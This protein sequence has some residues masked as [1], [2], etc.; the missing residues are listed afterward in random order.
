MS[1]TAS[2]CWATASIARTLRNELP[3]IRTVP[4]AFQSKPAPSRCLHSATR[5]QLSSPL[6]ATASQPQHPHFRARHFS[7]SRSQKYKTV[8][9]AESR[10]RSGPFSWAAGALFLLSGAGLILYFRYEK[11]RM[12][13]KRIAEATKGI[14]KPKVGGSFNLVDQDGRPFADEKLKGKYALVCWFSSP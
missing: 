3:T 7:T 14:G 11:A 6:R 9:Q 10:H 2:A 12:E 5:Q 4:R 8:Q 1:R 13:R